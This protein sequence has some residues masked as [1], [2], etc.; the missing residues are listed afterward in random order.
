MARVSTQLEGLGHSPTAQFFRLRGR[1]EA[2]AERFP[3]PSAWY[4]LGAVLFGIVGY[5]TYRRGRKTEQLT[6]IW[7]GVVLM[8][9]PYA[10]SETWLLWA[11]GF[12]LCGWA[13]LTWNGS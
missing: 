8:V 10:V 7:T 11:I 3:M 13:Y 2:L 5:I 1:A 6:L 9:Y 4:I 12:G